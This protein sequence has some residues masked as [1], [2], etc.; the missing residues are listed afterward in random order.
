MY[1]KS[2]GIFAALMVL[3][4]GF[5]AFSFAH[6]G[7]DDGGDHHGSL[8]L[9]HG[10]TLT[11]TTNAPAGATGKAELLAECASGTNSSILLVHTAGLTDGTYTVSVTDDTGT[12]TFVLGTFDAGVST[13]GSDQDDDGGDD[14]GGHG[15]FG[16]HV[17]TNG[18]GS[19]CTFTNGFSFTAWTNWVCHS[20]STNGFNPGVCTNFVGLWTN[21]FATCTIS[22]RPSHHDTNEVQTSGGS[23]VLPASLEATNVASVSIA[24]SNSVV[25]LVGDF[26]GLTN[27]V[28]C[29]FDADC[30]VI[31]GTNW[32]DIQGSATI[33]FTL[34]HGREHRRFLLTAQGAPAGQKY[35]LFVNGA[36]AG[37]ARSDK[38]GN[39]TI[40]NLRQ[41]DLST[42]KTVV[43]TDAAHNVVFSANF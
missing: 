27:M 42:V 7:G 39:V 31:P 36:A 43:V 22:N 21:W 40:K 4:G 33:T 30:D 34:V 11:A 2:L 41:K 15:H 3:G 29:G 28:T 8:H 9:Q 37:K 6:D 19:G 14:E 18:F 35:A 10:I 1:K 25:D 12:N 17:S 5:A 23:F 16:H 24:D 32:P 20:V 38:R 26:T 13:N